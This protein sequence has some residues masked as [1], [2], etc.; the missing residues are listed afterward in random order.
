MGRAL[1][2]PATVEGLYALGAHRLESRGEMGIAGLLCLDFHG[3]G[4]V[5]ERAYEAVAVAVL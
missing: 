5:R 2:E 3:G 4:L 1:D